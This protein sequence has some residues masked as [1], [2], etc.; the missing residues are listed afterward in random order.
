MSICDDR[1]ER[2]NRE[3]LLLGQP[4]MATIDVRKD[5]GHVRMGS[6]GGADEHPGSVCW[7][8]AQQPKAQ[9]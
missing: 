2:D 3:M 5:A 8:A 6:S 4:A 9:V 7:K 1:T